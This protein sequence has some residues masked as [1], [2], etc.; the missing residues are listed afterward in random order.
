MFQFLSVGDT[1]DFEVTDT[2]EIVLLTPVVGVAAAE[3]LIVRAAK[4]LQ[5]AKNITQGVR[6]TIKKILPMGGGL[7]G[8]SSNAATTLVALNQ[9][10]QADLSINELTTIGL[11]LGADVPVFICGTAAWAEGVGEEITPAEPIEPWYVVLCPPCNVSTAKILGDQCLT[12]DCKPITI[13]GFLS[14][15]AVNVCTPIAVQHYPIIGEA[16]SQLSEFSTA[17]MTGTGACVFAA[18]N[19][20]QDAQA[21]LAKLSTQWTGFVTKGCNQSPLQKRLELPA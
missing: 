9:L 3:N 16:L 17:T 15:E 13:A 10:W 8:G 1:L 11:E 20:Q 2:P 4:A 5:Q 21:A 18:F 19:T 7:G 12:R 6:I 14:G